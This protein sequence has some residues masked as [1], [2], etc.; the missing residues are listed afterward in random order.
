M[1]LLPR[2]AR[3]NVSRPSTKPYRALPVADTGG[4]NRE[5]VQ[6]E[7]IAGIDVLILKTGVKD[8]VTVRASLPAGDSASPADNIAIATLTGMLL[9]KGTTTRTNL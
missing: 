8:V 4:Q 6:R 5:N 7:K 2:T 9:D 1:T 3:R